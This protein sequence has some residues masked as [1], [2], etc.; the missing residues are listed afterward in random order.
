M[1]WKTPAA[2]RVSTAPLLPPKEAS[3]YE[4]ACEELEAV[5]EDE[6]ERCRRR[7]FLPFCFLLLFLFLL[8]GVP[9]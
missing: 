8:A 6:G 2:A 7:R 4:V 5:E 3:D 1:A 9:R